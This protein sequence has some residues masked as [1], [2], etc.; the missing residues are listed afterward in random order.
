MTWRFELPRSLS[1]LLQLLIAALFIYAG[2][3]KVILP[4]RFATDIGNFHLLPWRAAILL[5]FYLPWLEISCGIALVLFRLERGAL[6]ILLILTSIFI[7]ALTSAR[8][9]GIDASCGCFGHAS[10]D[11]SFTSHLALNGAIIIVL[12]VLLASSRTRAN[13]TALLQ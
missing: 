13:A 2:I 10:R 8:L 4:L 12:L 5:A 7:I 6:S 11:L 3:S 9:R 1:V